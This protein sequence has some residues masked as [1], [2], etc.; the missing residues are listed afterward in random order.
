MGEK[1]NR[2]DLNY[3][4]HNKKKYSKWLF[5]GVVLI[6]IVV[7]IKMLPNGEKDIER[8]VNTKSFKL[9]IPK[10]NTLEHNTEELS[11]K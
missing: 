8:P 2:Y 11:K 6:I 3:D 10:I 9:E 5:I 4:N 7:V 1:Y